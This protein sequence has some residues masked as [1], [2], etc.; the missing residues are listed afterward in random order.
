MKKVTILAAICLSL[1]ATLSAQS[2]TPM[3]LKQARMAAYQW[4]RDYNVYARM[5]SKREPA[6][7][8]LSLFSDESVEIF[9][10]Y[11]PHSNSLGDRISVSE[12]CS[13][14][15]D[16]ESVY[17]MSFEIQNASIVKEKLVDN[18]TISFILEFDKIVSFQ[19]RG[20]TSDSM[21]AYPQKT[22]HAIIHL[23]YNIPEEKTVASDISS[24][25]HWGKVYVLHNEGVEH[26]NQY[27]TLNSLQN[28]CKEN[29]SALVKW[30]YAEEEFDSQMY[31]L[32]HD[33]LKNS[34]HFGGSIG[35][36]LTSAKTSSNQIDDYSSNGGIS[37]DIILGYYRQF[38]LKDTHRFGMDFSV[39]FSE[40]NLHLRATQYND[41]YNEIDPDDGQYERL[42]SITNYSES[43]KR[44]YLKV[45]IALRY[46]CFVHHDL[47]IYAKVGVIASYDI[48]QKTSALANAQYSGYY[49]WLFD[50]TISQNGIYDFGNYDINDASNNIA[51]NKFEL[52]V[53]G[54]I[55]V[56]YFIPQSHWS[57]DMGLSYG[58]NV[59]N[60]FAKQNNFHL[61]EN[62]SD[63]KS[64]TYLLQ[65]LRQHNI[66]FLLGINYNF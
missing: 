30:N 3:Q 23:L 53:F 39:A 28:E 32:I 15:R 24:D 10:D 54:R 16:K 65:S 57:I 58:V 49:P 12:Y 5:E 9:N 52:G 38:L 37:Y 21:F 51:I 47:S 35:G 1:A 14:L 33:T 48:A 40:N 17:K 8:F 7:K 64:S 19:E 45:P 41:S 46:D 43:I 25:S 50:V 4:V 26:V 60:S 22:Y 13:L 18:K 61:S 6:K 55:G 31:H 59:Y 20:N 62:F 42:I 44:Y 56:Q 36:T 27:T 2:I 63:L 11:L 66:Q 34:L 29:E